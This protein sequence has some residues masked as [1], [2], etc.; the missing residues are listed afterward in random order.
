MGLE[1][2]TSAW[3]SRAVMSHTLMLGSCLSLLKISIIIITLMDEYTIDDFK[4]DERL[5]RAK[6]YCKGT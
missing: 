6:N 2:K 4:K 1:L 5:S 3:E